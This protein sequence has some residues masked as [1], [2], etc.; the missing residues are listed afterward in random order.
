MSFFPP[1]HWPLT[2]FKP[3]SD[4]GESV[5]TLI[6]TFGNVWIEHR[7]TKG[8]LLVTDNDKSTIR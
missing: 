4:M 2:P 3:E 6:S 7:G 1:D 5:E 8:L